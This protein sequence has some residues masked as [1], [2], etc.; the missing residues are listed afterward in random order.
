MP[1]YRI[2]LLLLLLSFPAALYSGITGSLEGTITDIETG[3]PL[4]GVNIILHETQQG[5]ASGPDG[6]F[7]IHNIRAGAYTVTFSMIGYQIQ[8]IKKVTIIPDQRTKFKIK[9][10]QSAIE[11]NALEII[12]EKPLIQTDITGTAYDINSKKISE[13]PI[14]NVQQ[15]V[16]LQAGA[17]MEG[18]IRGGKTREV[19]YL[20][21]GLPV[22]DVIQG[23]L[24]TD[25]PKSAILQMS[26][27]TG[28]FDAEYGNA[29]SGV[30]NV[31]TRRGE[32][33]HR[34]LFRADK[35]NLFS[36]TQVSKRNELELAASGPLSN[37]DVYYFMA[38][39]L[40]LTDTRWWQDMQ[41][42]FDSPIHKELNGI[43]KIDW[44]YSPSKRLGLQVLYS[45][46]RWRD[47]EFSWRYNLDGLPSR[48]RDSYRAALS[49]THTIS[50]KTFYTTQLS[51][52]N[53][54]SKIGKN[55][56]INYDAVPYDF[57][58]YMLYIISGQRNWLMELNQKD[59]MIKTEFTSQI[60]PHHLLKSGIEF[61]QYDIFSDIIKLEPQMTYF[62]KPMIYEPMLNF[63]T[64]YHYYPRSGSF[65]V[66]DK[67]EAGKNKSVV[68]VGLRFDFLDPRASRP[69][70]EL[71]PIS[72]NEFDQEVTDFVKAKIQYH[73][74]PR[75][76]I[77]FPM[78]EKSFFFVNYG[79]YFQ[80]PLFEYLYSGLNNVNFRNGVNVLR[81]NPNL[82]AE[83]TR[84]WEISV[85][86]NFAENF[87]G[88][89]TYF[90]KETYDQ[91]D[92]KTFIPSNS[93]I[94]GDYGFA[95]YVNNPYA[96]SDGFELVI[97][98]EKGD[99]VT[100]SFSYTFMKAKGLSNYENQSLN[101]AQWGFPLAREPFFLSW[102]QRHTFKS[103][104]LFKLPYGIEGN[105]L[106][107]N[108]T[109]RPYTYYPSKDGFTPERPEQS[110]LPNNKRMPVNNFLDIKVS[111]KFRF[112]LEQN[113]IRPYRYNIYIYL[114]IRNVL[115]ARNVRW[116]DSSGRIGGELYDPSAYY[117]GRRSKVGARIEF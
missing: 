47:Y 27:K 51:F 15:A 41:H 23:G 24:G 38:N 6:F 103:D 79:H 64:N 82:L 57:D 56:Q 19:V 114:D 33:D 18:N 100:G 74:S 70:V 102:D 99:W 97:S 71:I 11:L 29:L 55:K 43:G 62:G 66:Q 113:E 31:I 96:N 67:L 109:G 9:L 116:I 93:R 98:R 81:G 61:K 68:T 16:S 83:K 2:L 73:L 25:I 72:E 13:L 26:V 104:M 46:K 77:A 21:D 1:R 76:G 112:G 58:F 89:L 17:T 115:N 30:V 105:I 91:I 78:T 59:L 53:L 54:Y 88:T 39:T 7:K 63:S 110:F 5:T 45:L 108:H 69:A 40:T 37:N 85:R 22:Q 106:W 8:T 12:A 52:Y 65:Y 80:Y 4:V 75:I 95:E 14:D 107:H 49:W 86:N 101:Y 90:N 42:F 20:I 35:D 50:E 92:T 117:I 111:K 60:H 94:A 10:K 36:G 28:G 48:Q 34:F 44:L 84:A 3:D 32:K 87:V